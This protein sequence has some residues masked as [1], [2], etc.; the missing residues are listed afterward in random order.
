MDGLG[1]GLTRTEWG[2]TAVAFALVLLAAAAAR[3]LAVALRWAVHQVT[4]ATST[5]HWPRRSAGRSSC[6]SSRRRSS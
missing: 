6:W 3:L 4:R 2:E 1:F 5:T